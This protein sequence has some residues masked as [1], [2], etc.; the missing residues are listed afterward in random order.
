MKRY[1]SSKLAKHGYIVLNMDN[2][3]RVQSAEVMDS[4]PNSYNY[5]VFLELGYCMGERAV[6][7]STCYSDY[8]RTK[9]LVTLSQECFELF[10]MD[11]VGEDV[12]KSLGF[13][14]K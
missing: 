2:N 9:S 12:L 3:G 4:E 7:S 8:N 1:V 6:L 13:K 10:D 11:Y 14:L 5:R